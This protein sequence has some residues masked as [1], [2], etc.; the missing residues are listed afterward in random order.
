MTVQGEAITQ[1][2]NLTDAAAVKVS[3]LLD[4]GGPR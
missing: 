2:I 4:A 1:G 3:N